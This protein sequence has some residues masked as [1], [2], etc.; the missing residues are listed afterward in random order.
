[1][2]LLLLGLGTGILFGFL[3]QRG[4]VLRYDKQIGALRLLDLTILKFMLTA[5]CVG[6]V[7][8]YLLSDLGLIALAIRPLI[9]GGTVTGGLLF[10]IGW[11]F[12]GYCP[13]TAVGALAEGRWDAVFGILGMLIG[14]AFFAEIYPFLRD[15]L[16]TMGELG[17]VT[18]PQLF[19][20]SHWLVIPLFIASVVGF[21]VWV[22]R[23]GL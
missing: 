22:E 17:K 20:V 3:L 15:T 9:W 12:L 1:M 11:G 6:M 2:S 16:L 4:R 14:A 23:K 21:F 13:G 7:G 18:L 19:G 8:V 5:I 10:G